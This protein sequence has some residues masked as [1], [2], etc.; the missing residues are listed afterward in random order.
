MIKFV[1]CIRKRAD[2]SDEEFHTYWREKH[3]A[4]IRSLT[5][6]LRA[7]KYIQSHTISTPIN[8]ELVRGRGLDTILL[9]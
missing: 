2:L 5:K 4:F 9:V 7:K 6:V 1:Y 3:G 8:M